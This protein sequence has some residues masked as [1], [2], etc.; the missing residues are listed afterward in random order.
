MM[1]LRGSRKA[2]RRKLRITE[3]YVAS[4]PAG[5]T[6]STPGD[7]LPATAIWKDDFMPYDVIDFATVDERFGTEDQF[8]EMIDAIHKYNMH[9][10]MDLPI[11]TTSV[12]HIWFED[13]KKGGKYKSYYVW[14]KEADVRNDNNYVA[15]PGTGE[16]FLAYEGRDPIL[17][18]ENPEVKLAIIDVAKKYLD[19]GVDGFHL[20]YVSQL[21]KN[22]GAAPYAKAALGA[23]ESFNSELDKYIEGNEALKEKKVAV[24][25]SLN[26]MEDVQPH[27]TEEYNAA[28]LEYVIDNSVTKLEPSICP[29]GV[30]KCLYNA[31]ANALHH[32]E[33]SQLPHVWQFTNYDVSRLTSR[34]D[35]PTGNLM[36]FVQMTL[37]GAVEI[38]YGQEIGLTDAINSSK[39]FTGLMQ[40]DSS[41]YGGFTTA[42]QQPFFTNTA[43][44]DKLN[45][46]AQFDT[47]KS[48]LKTF[49]SLA[50]LRQRDDNL[51]FGTIKLAPFV[52]DLILYSRI[53]HE[54]NSTTTVGAAYVVATNFG[55]VNAS[56]GINQLVP[57][58]RSSTN[59]EV[60]ALTSNSNNY[61]LR[62]HIDLS[63]KKLEL[64]PKQGILLRI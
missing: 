27:D 32:F 10:V 54:N 57:V 45:Y 29:D 41:K 64:G 53:H 50:K 39:K 42:N 59:V 56:V 16:A 60:V 35:A 8:K 24:F 5:S 23:L 19:L 1:I 11:S 33:R 52:N 34:F 48:P 37:P 31:L 13:A 9:F 58:D 55:A 36:T 61:Q 26:D 15:V 3:T 44:I 20:A 62:Q 40:W 47:V 30:A 7:V 63:T 46:Q 28:S 38:Y 14:K 12:K 25:C 4:S 2:R 21:M 6:R 22:Q 43:D 49:R 17:N 18:W 51:A